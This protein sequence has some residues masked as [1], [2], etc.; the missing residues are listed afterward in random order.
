MVSGKGS[1]KIIVHMSLGG[2]RSAS[3]DDAANR[4]LQAY[5]PIFASAGNN[6]TIDACTRSPAGTSDTFTVAASNKMDQ[7]AEF[8]SFGSCVDIIAPGVDITAA[9]IG[10][11]NTEVMTI[12][13]TSM[14]TPHV[15]G[16]AALLLSQFDLNTA[17]E[18]FSSLRVLATK[19][20]IKEIRGETPN[21]FVYDGGETPQ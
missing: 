8:S 10:S 9:W 14:A 6:E 18:L 7:L 5:I 1:G 2:G 3:V 12:S 13:G 21:L 16:V 19:D 20:I 17:P 4:M 15:A 11:N